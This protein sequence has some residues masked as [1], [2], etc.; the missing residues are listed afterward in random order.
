MNL[1]IRPDGGLA[2]AKGEIDLSEEGATVLKDEN[3]PPIN[4]RKKF[5]KI[6]LNKFFKSIS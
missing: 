1:D 4:G 2:S 3:E 5:L 6:F